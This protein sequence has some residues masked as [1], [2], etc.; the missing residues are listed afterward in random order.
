MSN[1]KNS[2]HWQT[3]KFIRRRRRHAIEYYFSN[4]SQEKCTFVFFFYR[5]FFMT[6]SDVLALVRRTS[7]DCVLKWNNWL[8]VLLDSMCVLISISF[9]I[10]RSWLSNPNQLVQ[11]DIH[12]RCATF[13]FLL[14]FNYQHMLI[15]LV[16]CSKLIREKENIHYFLSLYSLFMKNIIKNKRTWIDFC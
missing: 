9:E 13:S 15:L 2:R 8:Y 7:I 11:H 1:D 6:K 12:L 4:R 14:F 3:V 5:V 10:N 16:F